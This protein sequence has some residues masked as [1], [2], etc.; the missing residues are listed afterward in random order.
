MAEYCLIDRISCSVSGRGEDGEGLRGSWA[1]HFE[2]S[3]YSVKEGSIRTE[4]PF[5]GRKSINV[6]YENQKSLFIFTL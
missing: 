5:Y 2:G 3:I 1:V 6:M 4:Y